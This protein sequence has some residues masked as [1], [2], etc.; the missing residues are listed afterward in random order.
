MLGTSAAYALTSDTTSVASTTF[1]RPNQ[2][3]FDAL[4]S[5]DFDTYASLYKDKTGEELT[6]EAFAKILELHNLR[7]QEQVIR[8]DLDEMGVK[9][10]GFGGRGMGKGG[11]GMNGDMPMM[12][13][14]SDEQKTVMEQARELRRNGDTEGADKLLSDAGIEIP[15]GFINKRGNR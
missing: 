13:N 12:N 8:E 6:S 3:F 14:L 11:H 10:P 9:M 2:A 5:K 15:Q 4:E 7:T 1:T